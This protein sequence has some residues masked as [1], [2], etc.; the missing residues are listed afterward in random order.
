[1]LIGAG[2]YNLNDLKHIVTT[3]SYLGLSHDVKDC[4]NEEDVYNCTSRQY[5]EKI[6]SLCGCLPLNLKRYDKVGCKYYI[7]SKRI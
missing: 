5:L 4:Q 3:E 7:H 6:L 1:M 2:E